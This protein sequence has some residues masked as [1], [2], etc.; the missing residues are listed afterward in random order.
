MTKKAKPTIRRQLHRDGVGRTWQVSI[1]PSSEADAEDGRFW[2]EELT[3]AERVMAVEECV[4]SA[5]LAQGWSDVPRLR[6]VAR[7]VER[8][9][10]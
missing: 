2:Y 5:L 1:V 6:R 7:L 3:P 4:R 8:R 10:R 9:A